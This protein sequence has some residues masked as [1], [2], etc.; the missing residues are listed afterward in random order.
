MDTPRV[1]SRRTSPRQ[2]P[3]AN[4]TGSSAPP[5][6]SFPSQPT[7]SPSRDRTRQSS[8]LRQLGQLTQSCRNFLRRLST[9]TKSLPPIQIDDSIQRNASGVPCPA[10]NVVQVNTRNGQQQRLHANWYESSDNKIYLTGQSPARSRSDDPLSSAAEGFLMQGIASGKGIFQFVWPKA[11]RGPENSRETPIIDQLMAQWRKQGAPL[12]IGG[13]YEIVTKPEQVI[14]A[15]LVDHPKSGDHKHYKLTVLDHDVDPPVKRIIPLTQAGLKLTDA[16]LQVEE[17]ERANELLHQHEHMIS[18]L[19]KQN[20]EKDWGK[21]AQPTILSFFGNGRSAT[22]STFRAMSERIN[23]HK[24]NSESDMDKH[25]HEFVLGQRKVFGPRYLPER[26]LVILREALLKGLK[27]R[28]AI[29]GTEPAQNYPAAMAA[30]QQ[31]VPAASSPL[32]DIC[33]PECFFLRKKGIGDGLFHAILAPSQFRNRGVDLTDVAVR[34]IQRQ[35]D[36]VREQ[37][38]EQG[39]PGYS[40]GNTEIAQWLK[41]PGNKSKRVTVLDVQ[42]GSESITIFARERT[43]VVELKGKTPEE[44]DTLIQ[45]HFGLAMSQAEVNEKWGASTGVKNTEIALYRNRDGWQRINGLT[46]APYRENRG[47]H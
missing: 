34:N 46:D 1:G 21:Q 13:R 40:S 42:P 19:A 39:P 6:L 37:I 41:L 17:I 7:F 16:A 3:R 31:G 27:N 11:P 22:L 14:R 45:I 28:P 12:W 26:Q 4:P 36:D 44:A 38:P 30:T 9:A 47:P 10:T 35:V 43:T 23:A 18:P 20:A 15:D 32:H 33:K 8:F 2:S 24:I 25:L 29:V 5:E